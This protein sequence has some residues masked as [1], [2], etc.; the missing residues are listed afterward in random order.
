ML[1]E[2][3][4]TLVFGANGFGPEAIRADTA[5]HLELKRLHTGERKK[6]FG[7]Y[8]DT[9][10]G[11]GLPFIDGRYEP[12]SYA[13]DWEDAFSGNAN[14]DVT[15][16]NCTDLLGFRRALTKIKEFDLI[17]VLHSAAGDDMRIIRKAIPALQTRRGKLVVFFGN[18]Y[19]LMDEKIDFANLSGADFVCSQLPI[20]AA[21]WLYAGVKSAAIIEMP[22]ALNPKIYTPDSSVKRVID[23]GFVGALYHSTIGDV[24]RSHFIGTIGDVASKLGLIS[25]I[26]FSNFPRLAWAQ[27]LRITKAI[28]GGESGTY[29]LQRSGE[30]IRKALQY[31][32]EHP[33][34]QFEEVFEYAFKGI[35]DYI[36]GK[37]ISSRHFEPIGTRT[38]Q[39]LLEGEFN[40]ILRPYEHYIPVRKDYSNL[41]EAISILRDDTER[42]KIADRALELVL[43]S[44]TYEKRV[45]QLRALVFGA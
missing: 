17:V 15:L 11:I 21:S 39:L 34:A 30:G 24:E 2:R 40:G 38:P 14:L 18:E 27:Y 37:C 8:T 44:H 9:F 36:N 45:E 6:I 1:K 42:E 25:D 16:C 20:K 26:R 35:S 22:H 19:D 31:Q 29:Y 41:E 3:I 23:V 33:N 7:G 13:K 10:S 32:R 43:E 12:L 28:I 5:F 4:R